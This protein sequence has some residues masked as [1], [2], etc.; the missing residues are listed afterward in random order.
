MGVTSE[1]GAY[2]APLVPESDFHARRFAG[3]RGYRAPG[4]RWRA[5]GSCLG[6]VPEQ[7]SDSERPRLR[8][9]G[10]LGLVDERSEL[11]AADG[12]DVAVLVREAEAFR[13]AVLGGGE[14]RSC[15]EGEPVGVLVVAAVRCLDE[16]FEGAADAGDAVATLH[17][18][19]VRTFDREGDFFGPEG[20]Q[21]EV[22]VEEPDQRTNRTGCIVVLG[23]PEQQRAASLHVPEIHV[24][25][26]RGTQGIPGGVEN[27]HK[28][29]L[30][31]IP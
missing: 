31:V 12:D 4:D 15:E 10:A 26:Q 27:E 18:V 24:V 20:L 30:G 28:L 2:L 22:L 6:E 7:G 1:P 13:V 17:P 5:T 29:G 19:A 3:R 16:L 14:Q 9:L 11:G 21:C 25:P 23:H 8:F